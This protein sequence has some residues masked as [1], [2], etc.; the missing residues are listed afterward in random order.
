MLRKLKLYLKQNFCRHDFKPWANIYGDLINAFDGDRT[1]CLCTKCKKRKWSKNYIKAP[2]NYNKVLELT[3]K[4]FNR[5]MYYFD[6]QSLDSVI[7]DKDLF[8]ELYDNK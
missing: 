2:L 1:V 7:Q 4:S 3:T 8:N 5:N 6:Q